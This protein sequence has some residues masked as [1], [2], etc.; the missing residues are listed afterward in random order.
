MIKPKP[1]IFLDMDQ[2]LAD[3]DKAA[4][5]LFGVDIKRVN[6]IRTADDWDLCPLLGRLTGGEVTKEM[7]QDEVTACGDKFWEDLE[8]MPWANQLVQIVEEY[9]SKWIALSGPMF[10]HTSHSGKIKWLRNHIH[11]TF[12]EFILTGNKHLLAAPGRILIDDKP[13]A[14]RRFVGYGG[15]SILFPSYG[16]SN[17]DV[18]LEEGDPL[19]YVEGWLKSFC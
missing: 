18:L 6:E 13:S 8:P 7:L 4:A 19:E 1:I 11:P 14:V 2:V 3:F 12:D 15:I 9:S 10:C 5:E 17:R 16:N